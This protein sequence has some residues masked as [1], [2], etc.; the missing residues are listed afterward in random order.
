M[1]KKLLKHEAIYYARTLLIIEAVLF[2]L[3][4]FT[5]ILLF[6]ESDS[7][8][9]YILQG[10]SYAMFGLAAFACLILTF[11]ICIVRFY[12]NLFS[13]EGYLS[14]T[15][16]VSTKQHLFTKLFSAVVYYIITFVS[17]IVTFLITI[18]GDILNEVVKAVVYLLKK[19]IE[20]LPKGS[21]PHLILYTIEF[22]VILLLSLTAS[23]LL[24]YCF[25]AIGQTAKKN[26]ILLS[27][28]C[29]FIYSAASQVLGTLFSIIMT[30]A[31]PYIPYGAIERFI[32]VH[33]FT[34]FHILFIGTIVW[35]AIFVVIYYFIVYRI[36]SRKLNL[37]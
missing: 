20:T 29:Y 26:R 32:E 31:D 17:V 23:F 4:L 36:I 30:I 33:P 15:L 25:I 1:V 2:A 8:I 3:A 21:T 37:E 10:S 14:F 35:S 6:F 9:Y 18:S 11:V 13:N 22:I 16:P 7:F 19:L 28:G 27:V 24:Y 5:R 12:K 34:F